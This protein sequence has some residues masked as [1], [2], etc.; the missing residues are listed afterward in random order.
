MET[1]TRIQKVTSKGQITLPSAW[2]ARTKTDTITV[3]ITGNTIE[4]S[5]A[6]LQDSGEYT[7]FDAIRDNK[8]KGIKAADLVKMIRKIDE[9]I[10]AS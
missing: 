5:P 1:T 8:G 7:V 4:I 6:R 10:K 2:R 3:K 9:R